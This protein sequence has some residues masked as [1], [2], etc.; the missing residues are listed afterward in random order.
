MRLEEF[1]EGEALDELGDVHAKALPSP[2]LGSIEQIDA[3]RRFF[4]VVWAPAFAGVTVGAVMR[5][6]L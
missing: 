1:P 5:H 6:T 4:A 2:Q 3:K